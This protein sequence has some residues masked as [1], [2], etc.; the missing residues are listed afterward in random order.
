[1]KTFKIVFVFAAIFVLLTEMS[2]SI[3]RAKESLALKGALVYTA[4][5]QAIQNAIILIEDGKIVAVGADVSIPKEAKVLDM[6]GKVIIPGLIDTHCHLGTFV[7][8]DSNEMPQPIGPENR[9]I[10]AIHLDIPDWAEAVKGGVTTVVT[11]PGSGERMGGQSVTIKTFGRDLDKRI[12]KDSG[13]LKMAINGVNLSHIPT[14]H[15]NFIKAQEYMEGWNRYE[16]GDKKG[17]PPARDLAMEALAK[18]L[19]GEE[20]VRVHIMWANDIMSFLKLKDEFGFELQFIHA[21]EAWKVADEIAKRNVP[22]ICMPIELSINVPESLLHGLVT[23]QR[24]GVK[25]AMHSDHPVSPEKWFRLNAAMAV[26]YGLSKEEALKTV[27]INPAEI[28]KIDD[29]VGSIEKGKDADLVVLNGPWYEVSSR[30]E[31]VLVDGAVAYDRH[32]DSQVTEG[33]E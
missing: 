2:S 24:E 17:P 1:M 27:T 31:M 20:V 16:S 28:A 8:D 4:V 10:D 14:I 29:R 26:R 25:L 5:G 15:A 22:V 11:G 6:T 32:Q 23:L 33:G 7:A 13:E 30:V 3:G 12:L 19:K 9:A 21:P 18:A